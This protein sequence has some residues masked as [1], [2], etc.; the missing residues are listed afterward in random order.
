LLAFFIAAC[1]PHQASSAKSLIEF[2]LASFTSHQGW[3]GKIV[4]ES[5][6]KVYLSETVIAATAYIAE[7]AAAFTEQG[8]HMVSIKLTET[9]KQKMVV[10]TEQFIG[11]PIGIIL[12]GHL[13]SEP[14]NSRKNLGW[15]VDQNARQT[16][17]FMPVKAIADSKRVLIFT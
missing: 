12:N 9:C 1:S 3:P 13:L 2:K 16:S 11:K 5:G 8:I 17:A 7:A 14:L 10:A 6:Q 15:N 4:Q